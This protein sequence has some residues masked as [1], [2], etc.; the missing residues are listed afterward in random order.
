M[1]YNLQ[2]HKL[3]ELLNIGE[4]LDEPV[5]LTGG[6]IH[7]MYAV[8]TASGKYAIK[9]LNPQVMLRPNAMT[10]IV[11]GERIATIA[12]S[13]I[14]ALP[15]KQLNC[16]FIHEIGGQYYLV[17]DWID[18]QPLFNENITPL[19][20][21]SIGEILGNLH[22]IDFS[23]LDILRPAT[24]IE[25]ITGWNEYLQTGQQTGAPW[26]SDLLGI[27]DEIYEWNRRYLASMKYL[28][29]PLVIGHGDIDPKNVMWSDGSPVVIDWES[30]GF[31]NPSHE[32]IIYALYWSNQNGTIEKSKFEAFLNG[33]QSRSKLEI[34]DWRIVMD[35]G[36]SPRWLEYNIKRSLGIDCT[37]FAEQQ[38]G[39]EQVYGTIDY[40][41]RY[42][43]TI[44]RVLEW[45]PY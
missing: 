26:A 32:F 22:S 28:E 42:E 17:Y 14:P 19:H 35:A 43:A 13:Y 33:Y 27:I 5:Q 6:L 29:S 40:L 4:L 16:S 45:L 25:N 24:T 44:P 34:A 30:A 21:K 20:C 7:R 8:E 2:F 10:D 31:L 9:A 36:L 38:L 37:D 18:G 11:N 3:C 23:H 41:R 39:T 15:A 12:A 1:Q